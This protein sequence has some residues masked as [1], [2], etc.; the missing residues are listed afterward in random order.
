MVTLTRE[1]EGTRSVNRTPRD[2]DIALNLPSSTSQ[3]AFGAWLSQR[4]EE[5]GFTQMQ[6]VEMYQ[7]VAA[8]LG[9]AEP[10][11]RGSGWFSHLEN[12]KAQIQDMDEFRIIAR[13]YAVSELELLAHAGFDV[14]GRPSGDAPTS[15]D[16]IGTLAQAQDIDDSAKAIVR[17]LVLDMARRAE[18]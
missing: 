16:V 10:R 15:R 9:V 2:T 3:E 12:S 11:K 13:M 18:G 14:S 8:E 6:A 4:R 1:M 17:R 5:L 7:D